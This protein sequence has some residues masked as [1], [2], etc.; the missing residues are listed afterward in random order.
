[1]T[2]AIAAETTR[3]QTAEAANAAATASEALRAT[4]AEATLT[5]AIAAEVTRAQA[6]ESAEATARAAADTAIR[7]DYNATIFTFEAQSAATT[8]TIVHNLNASFV[9]IAVK[10]QRADGLYYN[11][12]VSVQEF[13]SNTVKVY[14][15]TALKVKA[16]V[17]NAVTL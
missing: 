9:E 14:L 5:S 10:V 12:I 17:R 11:D 7:H 2:S 6:A 15:S 13:D 16:V 1:L 8:H 4:A 3:A